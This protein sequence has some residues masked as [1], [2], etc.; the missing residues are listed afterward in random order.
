M[1]D[2]EVDL[3]M[4][5]FRAEALQTAFARRIAPWQ[6]T[7]AAVLAGLALALVGAATGSVGLVQLLGLFVLA[8][9]LL[10]GAASMIERHE[11]RFHADMAL[12]LQ[13]AERLKEEGGR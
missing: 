6:A 1:D 13:D 11:G 2:R 4:L 3:A 12:L 7:H 9:L 10:F 8:V 5:R